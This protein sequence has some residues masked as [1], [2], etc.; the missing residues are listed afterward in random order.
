M[1]AHVPLSVSRRATG[2]NY[3]TEA[4]L[5]LPFFSPLVPHRSVSLARRFSLSAYSHFFFHFFNTF[6]H[7]SACPFRRVAAAASAVA[8]ATGRESSRRVSG[9][10]RRL[11]SSSPFY[12]SCF[13]RF[14]FFFFFFTKVGTPSVCNSSFFTVPVKPQE[15]ESTARCRRTPGGGQGGTCEKRGRDSKCIADTYSG[16]AKSR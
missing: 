3:F 7:A 4:S 15:R 6:S 11:S 2:S 9:F 14:V 10:P 13:F 8:S 1:R 16:Y 12:S 5:T